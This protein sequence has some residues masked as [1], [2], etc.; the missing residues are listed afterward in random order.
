MGGQNG[1]GGISIN[2][3]ESESVA[4]VY[5][6]LVTSE[7]PWGLPTFSLPENAGA[8][9]NAKLIAAA[10]ELYEALKGLVGYQCH[11]SYTEAE[12]QQF[13]QAEIRAIEALKKVED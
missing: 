1:H 2:A 12:R 8:V 7:K 13:T 9:A 3:G 6:G 10:P 11:S 4:T 5:L